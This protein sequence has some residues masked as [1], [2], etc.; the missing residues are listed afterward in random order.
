MSNN[1]RVVVRRMRTAAERRGGRRSRRPV[2]RNRR[3][4]FVQA[5]AART[6][7]DHGLQPGA[8]QAPRRR[9][10]PVGGAGRGPRARARRHVLRWYWGRRARR[11]RNRSQTRGRQ[12]RRRRAG[13]IGEINLHDRD[14]ANVETAR[15][16]DADICWS[17]SNAAEPS[18]ASTGRSNSF[19]TPSASA[20]SA[21][22][23]PNSGRSVTARAR[24]RGDRVED[25]RP[26]FRRPA[27]RRSRASPEEDSVGLPGA[28]E[29]GV[30]GDD[31][32]VPAE[33]RI[34]IA[35]PP[36]APDLERDRSPGAGGRTRCLGS[37]RAGR[38]RYSRDPLEGVD[39]DAVVLPVR[40]TRSTTCA[41]RRRLPTRL[42]PSRDRSSASAAAIRLLGDG[43]PT[44][45]RGLARPTSSEDWACYRSRL[46]S[47]RQAPQTNDGS[48][49]RGR[50]AA[51]AR[52]PRVPRRAEIHAGRTRA[53]EDVTRP[54]GDSSAA[55]GGC[56]EPTCTA[57]ST[58][59]RSNGVSRHRR[60]ECGIDQDAA[61]SPGAGRNPAR[62]PPTGR[63]GTVR[64]HVEAVALGEPFERLE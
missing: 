49:R 52:E 53:L 45:G 32:G 61:D 17:T 16:A 64:D 1:A 40:R 5:R 33:R 11:P 34:R 19:P 13:S 54:L 31:D 56:W 28:K 60:G 42:Q 15:F 51:A 7:P 14:L 10:E 18:P 21:R 2:G 41:P 59:R 9:R 36:T 39:A 25:R 46:V 29:R 24:H 8:P 57:C 55:R 37:V 27:L 23:S 62:R 50:I 20:S 47:G 12:R 58:T 43:S 63:R 48:R 38:R 30:V 35:V 4:Q 26:D 22:S 6:T 44:R 3:L